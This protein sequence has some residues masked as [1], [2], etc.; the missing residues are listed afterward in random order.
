MFLGRIELEKI[1]KWL[2]SKGIKD[3]EFDLKT[4]IKDGDSIVIVQNGKNVR[5]TLSTIK[6]NIFT[7]TEFQS[8]ETRISDNKKAIQELNL[9][10]ALNDKKIATLNNSVNTLDSKVQEYIDK[11]N[12]VD[13]YTEKINTLEQGVSDNK[14]SIQEINT[15]KATADGKI[16]TLNDTVSTLNS[17]VRNLNSKVLEHTRE[18]NSINQQLEDDIKYFNKVDASKQT[19]VWSP[20]WE[21]IVGAD[22]Y[23]DKQCL[24]RLE[25]Q[26]KVD[27]YKIVGYRDV[28]YK[29]YEDTTEEIVYIKEVANAA[30]SMFGDCVCVNYTDKDFNE[31]LISLKFTNDTTTTLYKS[32]DEGKTWTSKTLDLVING[33]H[34]IPTNKIVEYGGKF[35][36]MAYARNRLKFS[37][38]GCWRSVYL[39]HTTDF[40]TF[41]GAKIADFSGVPWDS[42]VTQTTM[43]GNT[44]LVS[45]PDFI[46]TEKGFIFY[47]IRAVGDVGNNY[48]KLFWLGFG[49]SIDAPSESVITNGISGTPEQALIPIKINTEGGHLKGALPR[50]TYVKN[51]LSSEQQIKLVCCYYNR[52]LQGGSEDGSIYLG[53]ID[54]D[55]DNI[56]IQIFR[57]K[58]SNITFKKIIQ[59]TPTGKSNSPL[60]G[61]G[62]MVTHKDN[63]IIV[64][65]NVYNKMLNQIMYTKNKL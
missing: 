4:S 54:F 37:A 36:F 30:A 39:I 63:I 62:S 60:G 27:A 58:A 61:N 25:R 16:N 65:P 19:S 44:T 8:L 18:I 23:Y 2:N 47:V 46:I 45:E 49:G 28:V 14:T 51:Y 50:I 10:I 22:Q 59:G 53:S 13:L 29:I 52:C 9:H 48:N 64:E 32:T 34:V 17:T 56:D 31:V 41:D 3:L 55:L 6:G 11:I 7:S 38:D 43:H 1:E 15:W 33:M 24:Y 42:S 20:S 26:E 40:E 5:V 35:Y 12:E 57:E 21:Y